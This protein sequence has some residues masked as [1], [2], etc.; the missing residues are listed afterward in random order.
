MNRS[1]PLDRALALTLAAATVFIIAN[2]APLMG[3]SA[4]GRQ[5]STT[6]I[7]GAYEMWMRGREF[8][9]VLIAFCAV[10]APAGYI[11]FMLTVLFAVKRPPAPHWIGEL[12]R[13][14]KEH[15]THPLWI[16]VSGH[17]TF[18]AAIE[19]L[20]AEAE[21]RLREAVEPETFQCPK[22]P[23]SLAR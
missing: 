11:V 2:T 23:H 19:R 8:T 4:V 13:W 10:I 12:M 14:A 20:V 16:V 6:I 1:D 5:A 18:D 9:A 7:G 22:A 17:G 3:L 15:C 21:P